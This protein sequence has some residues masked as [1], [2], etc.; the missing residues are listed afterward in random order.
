MTCCFCSSG[1]TSRSSQSPPGLADQFNRLRVDHP[2]YDGQ[3]VF[4][5]LEVIRRNR[6][7]DDVFAK[8]PGAFDGNRRIVTGYQ[9]DRKHNAGRL[10]E[11]I[12]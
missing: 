3:I 6:P 1:G 8:T 7:L 4:A 12:I 2:R 5:D 11:T 9:V 10:G